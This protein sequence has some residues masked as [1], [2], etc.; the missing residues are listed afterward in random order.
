MFLVSS[1]RRETLAQG[2]STFPQE[3]RTCSKAIPNL[4]SYL[5][6]V[7]HCRRWT[8]R[9]AHTHT[10]TRTHTVPKLLLHSPSASPTALQS[11]PP[12][13]QVA[14]KRFCSSLLLSPDH[15]MP[16][17]QLTRFWSRAMA[18]SV[19]RRPVTAE[20]RVWYQVGPCGICGGKVVL[21]QDFTECFAFPLSVSFHHCFISAVLCNLRNG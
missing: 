13:T 12:G 16:M 9:H 4:I 11:Q 7:L 17:Y 1:K 19:S 2:Q 10:H 21:G 8:H 6:C 15:I 20:A 14:V 18:L 3:T 5:C